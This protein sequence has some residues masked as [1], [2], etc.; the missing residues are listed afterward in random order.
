MTQQKI[1]FTKLALT[2]DSIRKNVTSYCTLSPISE[3]EI[4]VKAAV[5]PDLATASITVD[6]PPFRETIS[7]NATALTTSTPAIESGYR[8][9]GIGTNLDF[10]E[11]GQFDCLT[12]FS[13]L[14][15]QKK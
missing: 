4:K 11:L 3:T 12:S 13:G 15:Q 14:V 1:S 2:I 5:N 6:G 7:A 8:I 10:K 9:P